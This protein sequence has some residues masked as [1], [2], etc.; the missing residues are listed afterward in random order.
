MGIITTILLFLVF[1]ALI[2]VIVISTILIV[3]DKEREPIKT[4]VKYFALGLLSVVIAN[5]FYTVVRVDPNPNKS[6]IEVFLIVFF[7]ISVIEELSKWI[8]V[9]IGMIKDL[10]F[11]NLYDGIVF[12]VIVSLGFA[13]VENILYVLNSVLDESSNFYMVAAF[14]A[15]L[16]VPG[17]AIYG[18]FM[19]LFLEK[20]KICKLNDDEFG[21]IIYQGLSLFVPMLF[22]TIYDSLLIYNTG[23]HPDSVVIT[24]LI[25]FLVYVVI[26]NI[27]AII[28][29]IVSSNKSGITFESKRK[30]KVPLN[31]YCPNCGSKNDG[32]NYCSECGNKQL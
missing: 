16:A 22:H 27:V 12:A 2:P 5:V 17:H 3:R 26:I 18:L 15:F 32:G 19:G 30:K 25:I 9:K 23:N 29:L 31:V 20:A 14:R 4:L 8:S 13:G 6:F 28:L 21:N 7:G 10:E 24:M 11:N 1:I